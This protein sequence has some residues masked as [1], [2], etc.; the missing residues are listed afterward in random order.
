MSE[1]KMRKITLVISGL[2]LFTVGFVAC[3]DEKD[4]KF[5]KFTI[6]D[7]DPTLYLPLVDD[8]VRL[9]AS[10]NYNVLYD[11]NGMGYLHFA[12][13]NDILPPVGDF[14]EVPNAVYSFSGTSFTYPG[15]GAA[16]STVPQAYS[17]EYHFLSAD[18]RI[19]SVVFKGG[20]LTFDVAPAFAAS[21]YYTITIPELKKN[22][23][24]FSTNISYDMPNANDLSGYALKLGS[25]N[26][27]EV[28]MGLTIL[29]SSVSSGNY[30]FDARLEFN[31]VEIQ[32]VYGYFGQRSVASLPVSVDVSVF[33][34]FRNN[35][36]T[37]L[38]IKEAF[39][40]F[41]VD[42]GAGFPIQ[43]RIDEVTSTF[44]GHAKK[45]KLDSV[46]IPSNEPQQV[47]FRSA[48]SIGGEA[49]GEVLSNMPSEVEF[50]FSGMINPEGSKNGAVKNFLTDASSITVS[51][52]EARIP[53]NFSVNGMM[54]KDTLNFNSSR[55]KFNDMELL[56]NIENNMP[57]E[58]ILQAYLMDENDNVTD[59]LFKTPVAIPAASTDEVTGIVTA[60]HRYAQ[61]IEA[62]VE[63]LKQTKK[64]KVDITVNT[65]NPTSGY[66]RVT[67]DNYVYLK[68]GAKTRVN[69]DNLD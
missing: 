10:N 9:D 37:T 4:Y 43:L 3:F 64:I 24:P 23:V 33:D 40:D 32:S 38:R 51:H 65:D 30:N 16:F 22:G 56:M 17:A 60:P 29:S 1:E 59:P 8:T 55:V 7:L 26:A 15:G 12:I 68:I 62:N 35:A 13:E 28:V 18:Q 48:H 41:R 66:V 5:D 19:D 61:K 45:Y 44:G 58:V 27:F 2:I 36:T 42:N 11:A 21:G 52:I 46:I 57:V 50:Q 31:D 34:K 25:T 69:I 53:L 67:K 6:S 47:F 14:F 39:L 63:R 20:A 54:L 49:L